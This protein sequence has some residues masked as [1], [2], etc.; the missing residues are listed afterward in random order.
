MPNKHYSK[1]KNDVDRNAAE[2]LAEEAGVPDLTTNDING[3]LMGI[4]PE[5]ADEQR[6]EILRNREKNR[7]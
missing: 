7:K 6:E 5:S 2:Q 4:Y 3:L 1:I